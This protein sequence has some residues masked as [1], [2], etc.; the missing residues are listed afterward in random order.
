MDSSA[1]EHVFVGEVIGTKI[2]IITTEYYM[3]LVFHNYS[4][5]IGG[6]MVSVLTSRVVDRGFE[7]QLGQ[8]K[9]Y[10]GGNWH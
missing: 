2:D 9:D 6:V 4:N 1:F 3:L 7:P 5:R 10:K 8:A